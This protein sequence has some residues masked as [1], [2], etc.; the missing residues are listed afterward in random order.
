MITT[1]SMGLKR[2]DQPNDVFSYTELSDNWA[3]VDAH[4]H[5][6]GKGVQIPTSGLA[7]L[8]VT[9]SK[10]A[11]NSVDG[12]KILSN[13]VTDFHLQ[14]ANNQV[15]R[16]VLQ[17]SAPLTSAFA[18]NTYLLGNGVLVPQGVNTTSVA[19]AFGFDSGS[20]SVV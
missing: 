12:S 16:T 10:L 4:D 18:A 5:T 9:T 13:A 15:W 11:G 20:Y 1:P 6:S 17:A 8:A 2:W 7:N 14:S 3:K 19:P